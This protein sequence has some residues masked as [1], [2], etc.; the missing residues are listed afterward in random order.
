MATTL[1]EAL[2]GSST[3]QLYRI[4]REYEVSTVSVSRGELVDLVD[5]AIHA[6]F[7][8]RIDPISTRVAE[9]VVRAGGVYPWRGLVATCVRAVGLDVASAER[10]IERLLDVGVAFRTTWSLET[11]PRLAVAVPGELAGAFDKHERSHQP[12]LPLGRDLASDIFMLLHA[13]EAAT[14]RLEDGGIAPRLAEVVGSLA[15]LDPRRDRWRWLLAFA[16]RL[17]LL[18]GGPSLPRVGLDQAMVSLSDRLQLLRRAFAHSNSATTRGALLELDEALFVLVERSMDGWLPLDSTRAWLPSVAVRQWQW[19]SLIEIQT[20]PREGPS[21]RA[22]TM[23][24]ALLGWTGDEREHGRRGCSIDEGL[25]LRANP[26][27][28]LGSLLELATYAE[29]RHEGPAGAW[30]LTGGSVRQRVRVGGS[31]ERL[32]AA[33]EALVGAPLD[34]SIAARLRRLVENAAVTIGATFVASVDP[35]ARETVARA[36]E[37]AGVVLPPIGQDEFRIDAAA[38]GTLVRA[39]EDDGIT[40]D[41]DVGARLSEG[42]ARSAAT[43]TRDVVRVSWTVL[44]AL[45]QRDPSLLEFARGAESVRE[46]LAAVLGV[47]SR[48]ELAP[49]VAAL[50]RAL[51]ARRRPRSPR[52]GS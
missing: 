23:A 18:E 39:L 25:V 42:S 5:H 33:I 3:G 9:I 52:R 48:A 41:L 26:S 51:T 35:S 24:A 1:R 44:E 28:D 49:Q 30:V 46:L 7:G 13:V 2:A 40:V 29:P 22:T 36:A 4:A 47:A 19:M 11:A 16:T 37:L 8:G 38:L 14:R 32:T 45:A 17:G 31:I 34:R 20:L 43:H 27:A 6:G 12:S 50:T 10:S 15:A 21:V